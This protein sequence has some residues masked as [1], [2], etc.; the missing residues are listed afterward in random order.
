MK[1]E[2]WQFFVDVY[3]NYVIKTPKKKE[4][5]I[6]NIEKYLK[7]VRKIGEL[8]SR[9]RDMLQDLKES[10]KIIQ[11]SKIPK[12]LLADIKF[13]ENGK[14]KQKKAIVFKDLLNQLNRE[15]KIKEAKKL[16]DKSI[17]FIIELWKYGIHEKTFKF[18]SNFG[19]INKKFVLIDPFEITDKKEKVKKQ[20]LNKS[21]ERPHRLKDNPLA[22]L[23]Q[24]FNK[25]A[26]KRLTIQKLNEVW[27][28][29]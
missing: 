27:N 3:D 18:Y 6:P 17:E 9:V 25:Q 28:K 24:Y 29:K 16:I 21:W 14:I 12:R 10:T 23:F 22:E 8:D 11:K 15:E 4:E 5:M 26:N 7:S 19:I 20:L 2:G 13:L 1:K